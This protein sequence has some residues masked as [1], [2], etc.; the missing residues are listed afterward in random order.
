MKLLLFENDLF[1][2]LFGTLQMT[3]IQKI[4]VGFTFAIRSMI[5]KTLLDDWNRFYLV[6][7]DDFFKQCVCMKKDLLTINV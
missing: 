2:F 7:S 3:V 5:E 1:F 6:L 4:K